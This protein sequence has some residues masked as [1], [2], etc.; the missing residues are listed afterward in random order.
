MSLQLQYALK[1]VGVMILLAA[2]GILGAEAT[3]LEHA[4]GI[5][6][7]IWGTI[8]GAGLAAAVRAVEGYRDGERAKTGDVIKEDVKPLPATAVY[9]TR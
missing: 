6:P 8:I 7:A 2:L 9:A 4:A 5:D 3:D 1:R